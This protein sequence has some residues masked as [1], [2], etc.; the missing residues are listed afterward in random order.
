MV[1]VEVRCDRCRE[2]YPEK[3]VSWMGKKKA[4][5]ECKKKIMKKR[6]LRRLKR[7]TNE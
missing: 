5:D 3:R 4:C 2:V 6:E 1:T 7:R